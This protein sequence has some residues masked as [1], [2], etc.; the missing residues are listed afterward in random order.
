MRDKNVKIDN[1][2]KSIMFHFSRIYQMFPGSRKWGGRFLFLAVFVS[3][4]IFSGCSST[5]KK[6]AAVFIDRNMA[7]NQL[8]LANSTANHGRYEDALL[9]L[10]DARR[11]ALSTDDPSL[12]LKTSIAR[13]NYLFALGRRSEAFQL[14]E[15]A[16]AEGDE[17]GE[18]ILAALARIY[19]IRARLVILSHEAVGQAADTMAEE[20]AALLNREMNIVKSDDLA[21]AAGHVTMGMAEKQLRRWTEAENTVKKALAIHD[22]G[23][24]IEDAA[25][26]W[27]LIASIRSMAGHY[28]SSID[29]LWTS[30]SY[31]RRAEN[32]YGLASCWQAMGDVYQ[33]A[34]NTPKARGAWRRSAEIF[35][36]IGNESR[37]AILEALITN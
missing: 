2:G 32:G 28:D 21:T 31:D 8:N 30:I 9:I 36:A 29:A 22:K 16:S 5:P 1:A 25:Y 10:E 7:A 19:T 24:F 23:R 6:P 20:Y 13:G 33:K 34:G 14:W 26:D 4:V 11:L 18:H 37:A 35:R 12:R 3:I 15:S 27:F 17:F